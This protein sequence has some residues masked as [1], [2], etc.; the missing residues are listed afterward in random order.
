MVQ[1]ASPGRYDPTVDRLMDARTEEI[2]RDPMCACGHAVSVHLF[3]TRQ[4]K[5]VRTLC[6]HM[7]ATGQCQCKQPH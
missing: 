2:L 4:G 1:G 3:G 6:S 5:Q 7:D